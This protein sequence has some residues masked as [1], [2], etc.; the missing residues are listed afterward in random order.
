M[1]LLTAPS[2]AEYHLKEAVADAR[3]PFGDTTTT[4]RE[5]LRGCRWH[6]AKALRMMAASRD[7][8]ELRRASKWA[9]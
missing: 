8:C 3:L 2:F 5:T 7:A 4:P 1:R 9:P 6:G